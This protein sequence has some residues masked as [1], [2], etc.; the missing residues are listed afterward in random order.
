M[1]SAGSWGKVSFLQGTV[2]PGLTKSSGLQNILSSAPPRFG[3]LY[4]KADI[5]IHSILTAAALFCVLI[6]YF[7]FYT[8]VPKQSNHPATI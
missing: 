5:L 2:L 8:Y 6:K 1:P 7:K 4:G 3:E